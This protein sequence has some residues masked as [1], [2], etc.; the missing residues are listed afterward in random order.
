MVLIGLGGNLDSPR[1][2]SPAATQDEALARLSQ[3]GV[4]VVAQSRR[5]RT[6]PVPASDQPWYVNQVARLR[7]DLSPD[8]LLELL[9]ETEREIGRVR[10]VRNA[11]RILDLD[12]LDYRGWR[13]STPNL[14]LPHPR[15]AERGFVLHP[16][17]DVA[18]D[19]C[20]PVSGA[21]VASLIAAL[22]A[23]QAVDIDET[24]PIDARLATQN[25]R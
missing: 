15:L 24:A 13:I 11:A 4:A 23:S 7:T 6:A 12:L 18:P 1:F 17:R 22:P 3:H 8:A 2:G 14:I 20:H 16:L 25:L 21:G 10:S 19:W 9:L 5:Y